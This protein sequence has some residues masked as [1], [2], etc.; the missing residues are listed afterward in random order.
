MTKQESLC[1][2]ITA[3]TAIC[4]C[5]KLVGVLMFCDGKERRGRR[6]GGGGGGGSGKLPPPIRRDR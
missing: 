3:L 2:V 4:A 5:N 1:D 6:G